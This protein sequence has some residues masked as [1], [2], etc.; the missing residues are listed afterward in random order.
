MMGS[1]PSADQGTKTEAGC[2]YGIPFHYPS[3]RI[4]TKVI[5]PRGLGAASPDSPPT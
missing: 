3:L 1:N 2:R 4:S 5:N